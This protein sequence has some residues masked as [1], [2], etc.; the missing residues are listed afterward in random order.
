MPLRIRRGTNAERLTITPSEGELIYTTDQKRVYVGDGTTLGGIELTA[1]AVLETLATNLN[2][3]NFDITGT[4]NVDI[5][6]NI[7]STG[8][9]SGSVVGD[10]KGSVFADDSTVIV[11]ALTGTL[12]GN[13]T[14]DVT[15]NVQGSVFANDSTLLVD[16]VNG[17]FN[18]NLVGDVQGSIFADD[19]SIIIDG[20]TK[21]LYSETVIPPT[22]SLIILPNAP[23]ISNNLNIVS[24]DS[25]SIIRLTNKSDSDISAPGTVYGSI[26]F[27]R[28]DI[29]NDVVTG[30]IAGTSESILIT[31]ANTSGSFVESNYLSINNQ[32][33]VG[34]GTENP[35]EKLDIRG[36]AVV[37]GNV[38]AA[39][40]KGS[41]VGDDSTIIVD[42]IVGNITAPGFIQFGSFTTAERD[43]LTANAGMVIYNT[44]TNKFQG[45]SLDSDGLANPGWVDLH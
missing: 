36:N 25:R 10:V 28:D 41:L 5:D 31:C 14:G 29:N 1:E 13:L 20:I 37:S 30:V 27:Q 22:N 15:G 16:S 39:S 2:L 3:N 44:T 21:A 45:Y 24:T 34:L 32:G 38:E 26:F 8:I 40:F 19:S 23:S 12:T 6:G 11:D 35:I 7:T 33:K 4:G 42:S 9:I 17:S 18:G 43:A